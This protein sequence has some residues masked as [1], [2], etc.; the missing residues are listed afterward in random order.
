[1]FCPKCGIENPDDAKSCQSCGLD[2]T[3]IVSNTKGIRAKTSTIAVISFIFALLSI[4]FIGSPPLV[5]ESKIF[6]ILWAILLTAIL[7]MVLGIIALVKI[8]NSKGRSKGSPYAV[9]GILIPLFI[10]LIGLILPSINSRPRYSREVRQKAQLHFIDAALE[11]FA[12]EVNGYPP[13]DAM[14]KDKKPYCGAMKLCEAMMGQDL[15]G[16]HPDSHFRRDGTND[17]NN[18]IY[19]PATLQARKGPFLQSETANAY[20][21][22][23]IYKDVG[24]FDGNSY[25]ICDTYTK[26]QY[27]GKRTG[28]PILY[29]K[30]DTSKTNHNLENPDDPNNIYN[31]KD[32]YALLSLG[33]P[34]DPN[35][36][37]PLFSNPKIFYEMTKNYSITTQ[38]RPCRADSYILISAGWDGLYGTKDD[39]GNFEM[40][41]KP[42]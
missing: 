40:G 37:H 35:T 12:S 32:N 25:V 42:R 20:R 2:L 16:F 30:T 34:E 23:D 27:S 9:I 13:S 7:S 33:I 31:Y 15:L 14:D 5:P 22:K 26:Q 39:I 18:P 3:G 19:G 41:W 17:Y 1:M 36:K 11:L 6:L 21:L 29:Y 10:F 28:M 38:S 8:P 24:P 4:A